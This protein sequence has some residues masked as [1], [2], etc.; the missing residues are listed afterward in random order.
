[1]FEAFKRPLKKAKD[2][3]A[4]RQ[5]IRKDELMGEIIYREPQAAVLLMEVG[6]GCVSCP[7]AAMESLEEACMVHG[8]DVNEVVDY[9]NRKLQ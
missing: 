1:M 8:M 7:S 2:K 6:M 5:P 4:E 3:Q 9:L